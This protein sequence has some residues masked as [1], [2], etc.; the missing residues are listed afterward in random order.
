MDRCT[1]FC[2][3][4]GQ[5]ENAV[6]KHLVV[7]HL[8]GLG[9]DLHALIVLEALF[10]AEPT[11]LRTGLFRSGPCSAQART[12][13]SGRPAQLPGAGSTALRRGAPGA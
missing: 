6:L 7:P 10:F 8:A 5:T 1:I 12:P 2:I 13:D 4:R 9:I 11:T 3:V